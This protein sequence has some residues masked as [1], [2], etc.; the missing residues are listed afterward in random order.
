M[1]PYEI[2]ITADIHDVDE[3]GIVRTSALMRY[4]QSAA[5]CQLTDNGMS[6]DELKEKKRA[7]LLSRI[8]LEFDEPVRAYAPLVATTFPAES[9]GYSF[10]R[11]YRLSCDGREI[12]RAAAVWALIDTETHALV[13]VSEFHLGLP[14]LAPLDITTTRFRMPSELRHLG[15]Y[16]VTYADLDQNGHMNNTRYPDMYANFLPMRGKRICSVSVNYKKEAPKGETLDVYCSGAGDTAYFRTVR[17]DGEINSEAEIR[18][19]DI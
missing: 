16:A 10:L 14:C 6:Y 19:C 3:N 2:K 1:Q 8:R 12:G 9:H 18:L 15:T 7:F 17:S 5:Q 4:M 11:F 13:P